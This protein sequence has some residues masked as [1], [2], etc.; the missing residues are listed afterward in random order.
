VS[1]PSFA[2]AT[3]E[4]ANQAFVNGLHLSALVGVGMML[5]ALLSAAVYVPARVTLT[6][7]MLFTC[8]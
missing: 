1:P 3:T 5:A 6:A 4:A 7:G 2:R 8:S